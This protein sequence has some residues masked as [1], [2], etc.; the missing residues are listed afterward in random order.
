[1]IVVRHST[2]VAKPAA[3]HPQVRG[4]LVHH[5]R[6]DFFRARNVLRQRDARIVAGLDDHAEQKILD[7]DAAANLNEHSGALCPPR[8]LADRHF[9]RQRNL[10]LVERAKYDVGGH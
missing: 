2:G 7:A 5:L 1:M 8:L 10:A 3:G 6:E 4:V 9:V